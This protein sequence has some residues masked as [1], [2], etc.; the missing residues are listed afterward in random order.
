VTAFPHSRKIA[1][2]LALRESPATFG[3]V[4]YWLG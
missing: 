1:E 2:M 3:T 4:R